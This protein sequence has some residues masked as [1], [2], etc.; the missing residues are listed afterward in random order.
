MKDSAATVSSV[1]GDVG[2]YLEYLRDMGCHGFSCTENTLE[3]LKILGRKEKPVCTGLDNIRQDLKDCR[4]CRLGDNRRHIVFGE[5]NENAVLVFVGEGPGNEEDRTGKPFVG[6]AGQLL[7]R[8]IESIKLSRDEVYI[9][10]IVKCRPPA[11]RNPEPEEISACFPFL[12]RQIE[13]IKPDFICALGAVAAQTLLGIRKP[14]SQLRGRFY[15]LDGIRLLPT[16]H[17]SYLL[18]NP[19]KSGMYGRI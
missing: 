3:T 10:N 17:P 7:T 12:K 4:R 18:R 5:G 8:I 9:C 19:E 1:L 15:T 16:Y 2:N 13:A 14:I 11:N 6:A